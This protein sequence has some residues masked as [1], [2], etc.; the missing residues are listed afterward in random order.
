MF[1]HV[2]RATGWWPAKAGYAA[3]VCIAMVG[4][5]CAGIKII[6]IAANPSTKSNVVATGGGSHATIGPHSRIKTSPA[7]TNVPPVNR[8]PGVLGSDQR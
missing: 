8:R 4:I 3:S 7:T 5:V 2:L 6:P 1:S